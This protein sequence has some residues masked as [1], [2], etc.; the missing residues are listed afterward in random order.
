MTQEQ[1]TQKAN[2]LNAILS[3]A[4]VTDQNYQALEAFFNYISGWQI[5][6][7][8]S[9]YNTQFNNATFEQKTAFARVDQQTQTE[10]PQTGEYVGYFDTNAAND[11]ILGPYLGL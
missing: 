8:P 7:I 2:D 4:N 6:L 1:A 3:S 11:P 10:G 5:C 9:K